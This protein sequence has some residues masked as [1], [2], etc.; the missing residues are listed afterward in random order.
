M[1]QNGKLGIDKF[2]C[3]SYTGWAAQPCT[4]TCGGDGSHAAAVT[5]LLNY[6]ALAEDIGEVYKYILE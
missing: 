6:V 1:S 3:H 4:I 2:K 5:K